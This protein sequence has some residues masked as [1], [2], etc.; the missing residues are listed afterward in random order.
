MPK[1]KNC[2]CRFPDKMALGCSGEEIIDAG[3]F[4]CLLVSS[5]YFQY[6]CTDEIHEEYYGA[7]NH[8]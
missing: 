8:A 4:T 1:T 5:V 7:V 3:S 2:P 6:E